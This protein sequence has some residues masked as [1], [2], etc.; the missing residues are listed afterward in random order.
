MVP[1]LKREILVVD[2]IAANLKLLSNILNDE[3]YTVRVAINGEMALASI[4]AKQ[5]DLIL[6]DIKMPQMDG[7]E[8]CKRLKADPKTAGIPIIFISAMNETEGKVDA[9]RAG[10]VDYITKPFANEEVL[11][12]V[13]T[14]LE[15]ND[16]KNH[17]EEKVDQAVSE[18]QILNDELEA[19]QKEVIYMMSAAIDERSHETGMHVVRVAEVA[20]LLAQLRGVDAKTTDLIYRAAPL[21]D[22][23]KV[24]IPDAILNKPGK[25][26]EAERDIIKTHSQIGYDILKYSKRSILEMAAI[27]AQQHHERYDGQGYPNGLKGT[28]I[29]IAGR[30]CAIADVFDALS[31]D[32]VY[33]SAWPD[34]EVKD[35]IQQ[36]AGKAFDPK[37]TD[38][39]IHHFERFLDIN[40]HF[41]D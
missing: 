32:R 36:E 6:L 34:H 16:Y 29:H 37:L 31:H 2:D 5:P 27:I 25:L 13:H 26:T 39:F 41:T 18:I 10:G 33:K 22:I 9:F 8:V 20:R 7:F 3:H 21:H 30:I 23:G 28:D 11:A 24:S 17:L 1:I 15:L 4:Q 35:Y 38:L 19:T 40:H 12:R 14:H